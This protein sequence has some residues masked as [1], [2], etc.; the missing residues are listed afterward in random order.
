MGK[1]TA[2]RQLVRERRANRRRRETVVALDVMGTDHHPGEVLEGAFHAVR[3]FPEI[4]VI[5][6]GEPF[7]M[8][9]FLRSR[10]MTHP[11]LRLEKATDFVRM[12]EAPNVAVKRR[13][14]SIAVC[15]ELVR[16]KKAQGIV[17]PGNTGATMAVCLLKWRT[18][19]GVLR[20]AIASVLPHPKRP[21]ILLDVGANVD[22]K[23]AMIQQFAIMGSCLSTAILHRKQ[24]K[25][26]L[27]T[28]GEE[29]SKGNSQALAARELLSRTP[30]YFA[31]NAEGRD[32]FKGSFDVAVCDGFV[33]NIVLKT[34]EGL[35]DFIMTNM[36]NEVQATL[37]TS[38]GGLVVLPA[39]QNFKRSIDHAEYGG[40]P[41]L[42]LN[43]TCIICH[44]SAKA[45]S[46]RNA[47]RVAA[48]Q[49]SAHV[50]EDI[51]RLIQASPAM[52]VPVEAVN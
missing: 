5:A 13:D 18:I 16:E 23:P 21:C 15:A 33:G 10:G 3:D 26:G 28:I 20:P 41:L 27:L 24:P 32:L 35:A 29:A 2:L 44:G 17:S 7:T 46:I 8:E 6:V 52:P 11:R 48:E 50:N 37:V 43:G 45:R 42:G 12:D 36:K 22:C 14:T 40:A 47:I 19:E 38:L 49:V 4:S 30:I 25:V 51:S 39:L 34:C 31:G 9:R 1:I